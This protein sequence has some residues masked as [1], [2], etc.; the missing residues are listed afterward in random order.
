MQI[1]VNWPEPICINHG[2]H[3]GVTSNRY[4][5]STINPDRP[6]LMTVDENKQISAMEGQYI[7]KPVIVV[8][9]F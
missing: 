4:A 8:H 2:S 6:E 7:A 9:S 5:S 3:V 1:V